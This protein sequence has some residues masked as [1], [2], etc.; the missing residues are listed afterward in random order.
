[1]N[2]N[3]PAADVTDQP[4]HYAEIAA[5]LHRI[6]DDLAKLSGSGL[7]KPWISFGILPGEGSDD[8]EV[9]AQVDAVAVALFGHPATTTT[10]GKGVRRRQAYVRRG[11]VGCDVHEPLSADNGMS[12]T[13]ADTEADDPTPVSPARV[14]PHFGGVVDGGQL[15]DE[16]EA[17]AATGLVY[18]G[19]REMERQF[20]TSGYRALLA[21][22]AYSRPVVMEL[23]HA[24]ALYEDGQRAKVAVIADL[25]AG[26]HGRVTNPNLAQFLAGKEYK[27][28]EAAHFL[29]LEESAKHYPKPVEETPLPELSAAG[30]TSAAERSRG[31]LA[32]TTPVVTYFSFG[33]GQKDPTSG[34]KLIDHYV[35]VVAPT[36]EACREA[37]FA[38][39]F[40][41]AWSFDYLAGTPRATEWIPR[42]T[43][44]EAIVAPGTNEEL[45]EAALEAARGLLRTPVHFDSDDGTSACGLAPT[46]PHT[47][48]TKWD[49]V[50]CTDC[51][52]QAPF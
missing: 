51:F 17:G 39:R 24:D 20:I 42:W 1:M 5:E 8:D 4:D 52:D 33:H 43:E 36:Y 18:A 29:G 2:D 6:A 15:V 38:S 34:K 44:H 40:G 49:E 25:R 10:D 13:R 28:R 32:N 46:S 45:A 12:Y 3:V 16:T 30:L 50:N 14:E 26:E 35:T 19:N 22:N 9:A 7:P 31:V 47:G 41:R 23:L 21:A 37:M 48:A 11:L 27:R